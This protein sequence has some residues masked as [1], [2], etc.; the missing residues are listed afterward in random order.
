MKVLGCLKNHATIPLLKV[1][2]TTATA[3]ATLQDEQQAPE[4]ERCVA[5]TFTAINIYRRIML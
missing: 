1:T 4:R 5:G 2:T 3:T